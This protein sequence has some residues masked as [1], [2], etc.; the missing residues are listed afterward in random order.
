[1]A[2]VQNQRLQKDKIEKLVLGKLS[3][4]QKDLFTLLSAR[5]WYD[6]A[7]GINSAT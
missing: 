7:P 4:R 5:N 2:Y 3:E 6:D 1:M